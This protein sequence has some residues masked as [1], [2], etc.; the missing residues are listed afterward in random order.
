MIDKRTS[1]L[2]AVALLLPVAAF[3]A[4]LAKGH[5]V[6]MQHCANCHGPSGISVMAGAPNLARQEGLRQPDMMLLQTIKAGRRGQPPFMG[7]LSD[8][9][10]L[11]ALAYARTLR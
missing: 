3:A 2:L 5:R 10:I 8:P 6:Y 4:D 9:D 7:I 11:D 1:F